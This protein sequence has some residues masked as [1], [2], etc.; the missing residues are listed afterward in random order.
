MVPKLD[1]YEHGG[2]FAQKTENCAGRQ[3]VLPLRCDR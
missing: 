1:F 2:D 3:R